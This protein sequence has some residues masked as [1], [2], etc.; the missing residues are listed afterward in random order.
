[1]TYL[2]ILIMTFV[3]NQQ[4][5]RRKIEFD[6]SLKSEKLT[7]IFGVFS[8]RILF[9]L[10][11]KKAFAGNWE[12]LLQSFFCLITK[13]FYKCQILLKDVILGGLGHKHQNQSYATCAIIL[14]FLL[15]NYFR[16]YKC[17]QRLDT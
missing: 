17:N 14:N 4:T 15:K 10:A 16:P 2:L 11:M 6:V 12:F 3:S 9:Y 5:Q 1:M 13:V 7:N 8:E